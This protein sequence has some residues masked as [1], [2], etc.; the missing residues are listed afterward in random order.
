MF[1]LSRWSGGLFK[2]YH[3]RLP[4]IVG[5]LIAGAGF[6][7]LAR[8]GIGGSYWTT[9]FPGVVVLGLGMAISV[10]PL[11]TTVM[12]SVPMERAG[13]ASGVNNT[14]SRVAGLLAIAILGL[15]L[16]YVFNRT[17]DRRL[18]ALAPP[19]AVREEINRQR[20]KLAAIETIDAEGRQ[21]INEAFLAAFRGVA[22]IAAGLGVLS[23]LCAALL[24]RKEEG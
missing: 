13:I 20:N 18:E 5:P 10:A 7:L 12:S 15:F 2:R 9:F 14:V 24:I 6:G 1:L 17:L 8:P 19:A 23:S 16:T 21:A 3:A 4:L 11:T 22:L